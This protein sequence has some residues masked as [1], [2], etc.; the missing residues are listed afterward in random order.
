MEANKLYKQM[1]VFDLLEEIQEGMVFYLKYRRYNK[2]CY[3]RFLILNNGR[4]F[5]IVI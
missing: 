4:M 2:N 5:I 3:F 1:V